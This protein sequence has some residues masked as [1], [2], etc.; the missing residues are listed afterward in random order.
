MC[1]LQIP[2]HNFYDHICL[3]YSK[4][5]SFTCFIKRNK[6]LFC[7]DGKAIPLQVLTG[8]GR[9]YPQEIFLVLISVRG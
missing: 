5:S 3:I 2:D 6:I 7:S 8:A 1:M 4:P 9:L